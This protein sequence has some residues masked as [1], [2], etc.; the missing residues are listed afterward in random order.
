M[1][2]HA[3]KTDRNLL[4]LGEKVSLLRDEHSGAALIGKSSLH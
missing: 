2:F 4:Y 3:A 1:R